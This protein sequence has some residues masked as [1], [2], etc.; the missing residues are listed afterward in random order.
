MRLA[1]LLLSCLMLAG[2]G[3]G[4]DNPDREAARA[5]KR[6]DRQASKAKFARAGSWGSYSGQIDTR[7]EDDGLTMVLLNELRYTDPYGEVWIAP[8]G[9][10]VNGASIPRA[11]WTM[12]GGPFEGKYRNASVLHDVAYEHH[13]RPWQDVDRM[14]YNAMRCSGVGAFTAKTMYYTLVRHGRH[15]KYPK[16]QTVAP[17]PHQAPPDDEIQ[18]WIKT[19]DPSLEQIEERAKSEGR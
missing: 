6:L 18:Q 13:T 19:N 8:A 3:A 15:W 14:F 11:F 10:R 17:D 9:S 5:A 16:A 12:I 1:A 4:K 2:C 7:W